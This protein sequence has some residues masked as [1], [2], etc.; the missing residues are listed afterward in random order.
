M[1][2]RRNL[3]PQASW[4]K[5][6]LLVL[7]SVLFPM[8]MVQLDLYLLLE[9]II[10]YNI[11]L[12]QLK[13]IRA[14]ERVIWSMSTDHVKSAS[15]KRIR[16]LIWSS[17]WHFFRSRLVLLILIHYMIDAIHECDIFS[18]V[19]KNLNMNL[20][21]SYLK[22]ILVAQ[23]SHEPTTWFASQRR[24]LCCLSYTIKLSMKVMQALYNGL[25]ILNYDVLINLKRNSLTASPVYFHIFLVISSIRF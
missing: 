7:F 16:L 6:N 24:E 5:Y 23:L 1:Y 8:I 3:S 14:N 10:T 21:F 13:F 17:M 4:V 11:G 2:R 25:E 15:Q 20:L 12:H 9:M 19:C 18:F 22:V